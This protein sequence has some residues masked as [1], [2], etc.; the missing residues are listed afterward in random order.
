MKQI[1]LL[2]LSLTPMHCKTEYEKDEGLLVLTKDNYDTAVEEFDHLLVYFWAP[3]CGHCQALGPELVKANQM[4]IEEDSNI[5]IGQVNGVEE[6]E[7]L[8]KYKVEGYP[9]LFFYRNHEKIP[10]TGR[11]MAPEIK[12]WL[13]FKVS[14]QVKTLNSL[15]EVNTFIAENE[16]AAVGYF[17]EDTK[18]KKGYQDACI[19][20]DD[21]G[22]HYPIGITDNAEALATV[23]LDNGVVLH[24]K[25]EEKP[26]PYSGEY[27][28]QKIR[29][30]ITVNALPSVT[31]MSHD[32]AQKLFKAPND[33][34]S[35][36]LVFHNKSVDTFQSEME[37]LSKV[38]KEFKDKVLFV[39]VNVNENDH[40]RMIEFL[41]VRHRINND[42]FPS[43]R[44]VQL[45]G[46]A[47]A[48]I[49]YKPD[50][51][52]VSEDN[53]RKFVSD[54]IDGKVA[55]DYF[56]EP[57]PK[58]W[59]SKES[60]YITAV[61]HNEFIETKDSNVL[62]MY[63]APW[64]GHCKVLMPVWEDLAAKYKDKGVRVGKMD[65][66]MNEIEGMAGI[67][68]FPTIRLYKKD[69]TQSEYNGERTVEGITKFIE[70]DGVFGM[71]APDH[72]EL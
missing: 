54:Y 61:N 71:A 40:R 49:R 53:V 22:V 2:L 30:F 16:V 27:T 28:I 66:T 58:D 45:P 23:G 11:R 42:T 38:G 33:G 1:F 67:Y 37:M 63:F 55:R 8:E 19:D 32:N 62:V 10:Y 4:L 31:E 7:L 29:D 51:T 47:A 46:S 72:D 17:K 24:V 26:I 25:F 69:G 56:V 57:L 3:W 52:T 18:E 50:D 34:K 64:C 70:S 59:D 44:I 68:S 15:E 36:L 9:K 21:Y 12:E 20:Y 14:Q 35:H 65:A 13:E 43:M 5:R 6:K 41:G 48:P 60:K 39:S